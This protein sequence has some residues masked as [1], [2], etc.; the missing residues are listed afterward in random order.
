NEFPIFWTPQ[1]Q[2]LQQRIIGKNHLKLELKDSSRADSQTAIAWRWGPYYPLPLVIDIAY[3]L[4]ENTFNGQNQ[5][6]LE[7]VGVRSPEI[8]LPVGPSK[9]QF[10]YQNRLY[11]C[12]YHPQQPELRIQNDRGKILAWQPGQPTG[13]LGENRVTAQ[14]VDVTQTPYQPLITLAMTHLGQN[15]P[16]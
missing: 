11:Q 16:V 3:K 14:T 2:V 6:Q 10:T 5:L 9:T 12:S 8:S 15:L 13:L 7:L 1:V 4:K